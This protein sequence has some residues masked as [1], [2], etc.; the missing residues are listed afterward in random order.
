MPLDSDL[1]LCLHALVDAK[2]CGLDAIEA[3]KAS[4]TTNRHLYELV[5]RCWLEEEFPEEMVVGELIPGYK[6]KGSK[7]DMTKS[8]VL[9]MLNH[10]YKPLW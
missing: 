9:C 7:D 8:R 3:Y 5:K 4:P 1:E 2:K 6:N 10:A